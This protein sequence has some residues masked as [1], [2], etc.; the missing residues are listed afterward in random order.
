MVGV[1]DQCASFLD[2]IQL[3][4]GGEIQQTDILVHKLVAGDGV[5]GADDVEGVEFPMN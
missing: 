1:K 4:L 3:G 2:S 5:G